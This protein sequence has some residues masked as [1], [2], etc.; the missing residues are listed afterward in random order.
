[1]FKC[2]YFLVFG[3]LVVMAWLTFLHL[4]SFDNITTDSTAKSTFGLPKPL[5]I[6]GVA[7]TQ[8][9]YTFNYHPWANSPSVLN[10]TIVIP[11]L[12]SD[13]KPQGTHIF[14]DSDN[15]DSNNLYFGLPGL[16]VLLNYTGSEK[17]ILPPYAVLY[18]PSLLSVDTVRHVGGAGPGQGQFLLTLP[19]AMDTGDYQMHIIVYLP[20]DKLT[21][22]PYAVPGS[23][24]ALRVLAAAPITSLAPLPFCDSLNSDQGPGRWLRVPSQQQAAGLSTRDGWIWAPHSCRF[25]MTPIKELSRCL[26]EPLW[27]MIIGTSTIRGLFFMAMELIL[28]ETKLQE[29]NILEFWKCWGFL[30]FQI[31]NFR[32]S[33]R[34]SRLHYSDKMLSDGYRDNFSEWM[35]HNVCNRKGQNNSPHHSVPH[36]PGFPSPHVIMAESP[37]DV[38]DVYPGCVDEY[39]ALHSGTFVGL[40]H[41]PRDNT[42]ASQKNLAN[43][44]ASKLQP[45]M[46]VFPMSRPFYNNDRMEF[47]GK[48]I[49]FVHTGNCY[50]SEGNPTATHVCSTVMEEELQMM[51]HYIRQLRPGDV[52]GKCGN[53]QSHSEGTSG[54]NSELDVTV[55]R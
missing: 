48:D 6:L 49:H 45:Y 18:G 13:G 42:F 16:S 19:T 25:Q 28:S 1:M 2:V 29:A 32:I 24:F 34:D 33:Y 40:S 43:E 46:D 10:I 8:K 23:P 3:I 17:N 4:N 52:A 15:N 5:E 55:C 44:Y 20:D 21:R 12:G 9:D 39:T 41:K 47:N 54:D 53:S 26:Q 51:M 27:I 11:N 38:R 37:D 36:V 31:G 7:T 30:D 50:A 22:V 35:R 14:T